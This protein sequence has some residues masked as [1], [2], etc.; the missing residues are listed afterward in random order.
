MQDEMLQAATKRY[1]MLPSLK[2]A[3]KTCRMCDLGWKLA[4]GKLDPHV[5]SNYTALSTPH[6]FLICGQ[7]PGFNEVNEGMPFVGAAG[8]NF[9]KAIMLSGMWR[10]DNFYITNACKCFSDGNVPPTPKQLERCEPF[11][12]MEIAIVK[13]RLVIAFGAV[14]FGV[15][16]G[17][18][19]FTPS[20]GKIVNS[21]K[22]GVKVYLTYHPSPLNLSDP[23][24]RKQ[25]EKDIRI[26]SK[27][28]DRYLT[29]F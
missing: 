18:L 17:N 24:R 13:P 21:E 26:L 10:R 23:A 1:E 22:F 12:R 27:I 3:C 7:N 28:M 5:F 16:C 9:N 11:L 20:I 8:E 14:A 2:E 25:F 4:R 15:L 29:P 19:D 6:Q